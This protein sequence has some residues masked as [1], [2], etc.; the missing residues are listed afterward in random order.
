MN[1]E[2][3]NLTDSP[4]Q[5]VFHPTISMHR[6]RTVNRPNRFR[7]GADSTGVTVTLSVLTS[8]DFQS[9]FD[10]TNSVETNDICSLSNVSNNRKTLF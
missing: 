10:R 3:S 8:N 5:D 6:R 9:L 7:D 1:M 2:L 4:C